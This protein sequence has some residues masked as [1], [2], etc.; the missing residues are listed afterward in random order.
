MLF[1]FSLLGRFLFSESK[2]TSENNK[3]CCEIQ[4][5]E[6]RFAGHKRDL[7]ANGS[8]CEK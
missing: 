2:S 3:D 1:F 4:S 6:K 7:T 8:E 5:E